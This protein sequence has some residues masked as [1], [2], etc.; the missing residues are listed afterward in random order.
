MAWKVDERIPKDIFIKLIIKKA[1]VIKDHLKMSMGSIDH[2][3][4]YRTHYG[5]V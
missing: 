1:N 3:G 4:Q 2:S 5:S